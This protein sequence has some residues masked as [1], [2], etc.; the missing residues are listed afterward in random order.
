MR[1]LIYGDL[2]KTPSFDYAPV[3][4]VGYSPKGNA[5][6]IVMFGGNPIEINLMYASIHTDTTQE[7]MSDKLKLE[8]VEEYVRRY[9]YRKDFGCKEHGENGYVDDILNIIVA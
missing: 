6:G 8:K 2:I 7:D 3:F 4:F 1:K 9:R 5:T